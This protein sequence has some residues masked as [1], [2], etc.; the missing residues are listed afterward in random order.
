MYIR[1]I[2]RLAI[3]N[4]IHFKRSLQSSYNLS[5]LSGLKIKTAAQSGLKI[6]L[7]RKARNVGGPKL[8]SSIIC[9]VYKEIVLVSYSYWIRP[10][11]SWISFNSLWVDG[12]ISRAKDSCKF[13]PTIS[14]LPSLYFFQLPISLLLFYPNTIYLTAEILCGSDLLWLTSGA[15]ASGLEVR[16]G[17]PDN[18]C[19]IIQV[20]PLEQTVARHAIILYADYPY[21]FFQRPFHYLLK[22]GLKSKNFIE[23]K[24]ISL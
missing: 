9:Y 24:S 12:S 1:V 15:Q 17:V 13:N 8:T 5:T 7:C 18:L 6:L 2:V 3:C 14:S 22:M 23:E 11:S 19:E 21:L 20:P 4:V 10:A 16:K